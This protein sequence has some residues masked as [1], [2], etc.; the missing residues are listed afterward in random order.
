MKNLRNMLASGLFTAGICF[1]AGAQTQ[2]PLEDFFKN[3]EKID[4]QVSPDGTYFSFMAP[5]E[6]RMNIF[7]QKIGSD[8]T[9]R[10]TSETERDIAASMWAGNN[11]ILS[12]RIREATRITSYMA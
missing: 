1:T 11:R 3:P 2:I 7:V 9:I 6:N 4:Y 10:I 8:T 5:Y 12:S